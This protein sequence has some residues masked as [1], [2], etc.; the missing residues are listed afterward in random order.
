MSEPSLRQARAVPVAALLLKPVP[1][2]AVPRPDPLA[3][4]WREGHAAALAQARPELEALQRALAESAARHAAELAEVRALALRLFEG[5]ES[6]L[7]RELADLAHGAARAVLATEPGVSL[8]TLSALIADC[9]SGLAG[10]TLYVAPAD[11]E[12]AR[13][14]CP[15]GWALAPRDSLPAGTVEAESGPALQRQSLTDRLSALLGERP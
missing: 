4:G 14:L 12:S 10:G 13:P 8:E 15:Q 3:D 7:A 6:L 2:Q 5:L 1:M 9:L 11:L